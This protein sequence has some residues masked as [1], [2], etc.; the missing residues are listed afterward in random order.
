[1]ALLSRTVSVKLNLIARDYTIDQET[2]IKLYPKLY[3]GLGL[4]Q[5]PYTIKLKPDAKPFSIKVPRRVPLPVFGKVKEL[6][7]MEQ[8]GII[9]RVEKPTDWCCGIVVV[10]KK[11]KEKV[12]ICVDMTPLNKCDVKDTSSPACSRVLS[13]FQSLTQQ[14]YLCPKSQPS[15]YYAVWQIPL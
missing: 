15:F 1:M 4:V 10:P 5:K 12:C 9:S 3:D 6:E 14:Q 2:V 8:L 13:T 11:D 7:K